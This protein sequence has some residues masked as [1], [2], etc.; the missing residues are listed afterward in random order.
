M[1]EKKYQQLLVQA[2]YLLTDSF[3]E[4]FLQK[5]NSE[6]SNH[7]VSLLAICY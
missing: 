3:L 6:F 4:C 7:W 5:S 1:Q 2:I